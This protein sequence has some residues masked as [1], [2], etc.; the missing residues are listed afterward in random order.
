MAGLLSLTCLAMYIP[1]IWKV[2]PSMGVA[3][4]GVPTSLVA[5]YSWHMSL[6]SKMP[7]KYKWFLLLLLFFSIGANLFVSGMQ[8][9]EPDTSTLMCTHFYWNPDGLDH[10]LEGQEYWVEYPGYTCKVVMDVVSGLY[11]A[12]VFL[13]TVYMM[14]VSIVL[15][16]DAWILMRI[17]K[18]KE[19]RSEIQLLI[20]EAKKEKLDTI[21][22]VAMISA[23]HFICVSC[24]ALHVYSRRHYAE[25]WSV[26]VLMFPAF[27]AAVLIT[28]R[29][30]HDWVFIEVLACIGIMLYAFVFR[31]GDKSS[32]VENIVFYFQIICF[33][34]FNVLLNLLW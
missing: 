34:L 8:T 6:S 28:K 22:M 5:G 17:H 2:I 14:I 33:V 25:L 12:N 4:A 9:H 21:Q 20:R 26:S 23:F 11:W 13:Q 32:L 7:R 16:Y 31:R 19:K 27:C 29:H 3:A 24:L 15:T 30:Y 10:P 18:E 1:A